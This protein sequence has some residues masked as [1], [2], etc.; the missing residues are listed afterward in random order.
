MIKPMF[1]EQ[2]DVAPDVCEYAPSNT[3]LPTDGLVVG[4]CKL[5]I[6]LYAIA[7][8]TVAARSKT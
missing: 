8:L 2:R 5:V 7:G 3:W 1:Q 4:V 6:L